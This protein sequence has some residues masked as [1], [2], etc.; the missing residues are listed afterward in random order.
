MWSPAS[1]VPRARARRGQ[2]HPRTVARTNEFRRF[3]WHREP[4]AD[5]AYVFLGGTLLE[6]EPDPVVNAAR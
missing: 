4:G 5:A 2:A 3:G 6:G 1:E